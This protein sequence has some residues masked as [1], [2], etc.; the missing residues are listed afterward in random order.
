MTAIQTV[1]LDKLS[2]HHTIRVRE[3]TRDAIVVVLESSP[4]KNEFSVHT[5]LPNGESVDFFW[6]NSKAYKETFKALPTYKQF[7]RRQACRSTV[8]V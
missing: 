4:A 2:T 7:V 8:P 6:F 3:Y 5:I 1:R